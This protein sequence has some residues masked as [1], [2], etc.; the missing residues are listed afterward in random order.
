VVARAVPVCDEA[1]CDLGAI[2][3]VTACLQDHIVMNSLHLH[4][5]VHHHVVGW[6]GRIFDSTLTRL[7]DLSHGTK[8]EKRRGRKKGRGTERCTGVQ[9]FGD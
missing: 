6:R 8:A 1:R 9:C 7:L 4:A 2:W 5:S 3:T